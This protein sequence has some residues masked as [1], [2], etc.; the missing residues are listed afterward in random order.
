MVTR[1]GIDLHFLPFG[2]KIVESA[3]SSWCRA[4]CHRQDALKWVRFPLSSIMKKLQCR[5]TGVFFMVTRTGIEPML[6][7]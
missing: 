5:S 3:P 7:P 6:P 2:K 4:S 1:T